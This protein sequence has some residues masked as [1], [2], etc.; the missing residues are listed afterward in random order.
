[1]TLCLFLGHILLQRCV[2]M[3]FVP[4]IYFDFVYVKTA[5][6]TQTNFHHF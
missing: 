5:V 6:K 3:I 1:M 2:E 4:Y